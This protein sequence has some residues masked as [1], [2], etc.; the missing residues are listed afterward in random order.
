MVIPMSHG[1]KRGGRVERKYCR[2]VHSLKPQEVQTPA[3][4]LRIE[5]HDVAYHEA[6]VG[7]GLKLLIC[8]GS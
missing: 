1:A 4:A 5:G 8:T 3:S 6:A 2:P 7:A